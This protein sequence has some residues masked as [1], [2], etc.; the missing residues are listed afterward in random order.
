MKRPTLAFALLTPATVIMVALLVLPVGYLIRFSLFEGQGSIQQLGGFTL[1]NYIKLFSD[2]FYV[3]ILGKTVWLSFLT[4]VISA[5][6]GYL[7]AHFMWR[8]PKEWRG[9]LTIL[10][11]SPLLVSIVVSSYGWI[12]VLGNNGVINDFLQW[13]GLT[14]APIKIMFTD[15]AIVIGLV[16]IVM[17]FMVLSILAALERIDPMLVEAAATLGAN[18]FRAI[19][20][21]V[22]PLALPGIGAG[23]TIV[24]SLAISAYV[25]PAVL[26]GSGPNFITTL[27]FHQFVTLFNW[28]FGATVAALLLAVAL[29][30]VFLYVRVLSR[31]GALGT[32]KEAT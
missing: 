2:T 3:G 15:A 31:L 1:D 20:H 27:V 22:L 12:V 5:F 4:T 6:T 24:F 13:I 17:P 11:L 18:R 19:F 30:I 32:R 9:A 29:G 28:P 8:A 26:G 21:V 23:T 14:N 25:T 10:V 7:L 16:H